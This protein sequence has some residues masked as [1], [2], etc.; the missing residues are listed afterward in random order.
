MSITKKELFKLCDENHDAINELRLQSDSTDF[1]LATLIQQLKDG[2]IISE[3]GAEPQPQLKQLDQSIFN[4]LDEKWRF[5]AIDG[6]RGIVTVFDLRPIPSSCN[7]YHT[8]TGEGNYKDLY[9]LT[10]YDTSNWQNSLIERESKELK[11][12]FLVR[13]ML[14]SGMDKV[15]VRVST[16][17]SN[18]NTRPIT[19][20]RKDGDEIVTNNSNTWEYMTAI[21]LQ[22]EPLTASEA[23]L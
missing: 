1:V 13:A 8:N 19:F 18:F 22:G 12:K 2:G 23:G 17:N 15:M 9:E 7:N 4:G 6:E 16:S 3:L 11:G 10:G 14:D 21:N 20:A 5:A